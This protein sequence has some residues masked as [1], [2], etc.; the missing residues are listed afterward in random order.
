MHAEVISS[1]VAALRLNQDRRLIRVTTALDP[2]TFIVKRFEGTETVSA[3]HAFAVDLL[4]AQRRLELKQLV[5]QP[6]QLSLGDE[7]DDRV[8]HGYVKEFALI[9]AEG[10]LAAYR[11][12]VAPWFAFLQYTSNCRIFQDLS[13]LEIVEQVFGEYP[14]LA[15]YKYELN[16]GNFPKLSYCVQYNESDFTFVSRLLE[17]A[18]I[19]YTFVHADGAHTMVLAD[20]ST[21]STALGEPAPVAFVS[22]QGVLR[23]PGL[24]SWSARR[25]VGPTAHAVSSFDFKQ[26]RTALSASKARSI[27]IGALPE[28]ERYH[29]DGAARFAD[30]RV[31]DALAAIRSEEAVWP[32]KLFEGAGNSTELQA[33]GCFTLERHPDFIGRSED[34]RQFFVVQLHREGRNNFSSDYSQAEA[35]TYLCSATALRRKIPYRPLRETPQQRM[36]GPQTATVVGPPGEELYADR[37][38]RV[39]VQFHWDR[40]GQFREN[41]SC[42]IRSASPWA[43]A[44]MGGVSPPRVGQEVVVDF[45]D[46]DPD[47]PIITGRVF[48]EDNMPPFGME[49][50]GLKSK[51]VKGGGYNE[52]T[53]HDTAGGELLNMRAQ[54]DMVTTVL[55][56]QNATVKNNK[57]TSVA[58]DH[59]MDVGSNQSISVGA[60]RGITVTGNDMLGVTGTR[61]TSVTGAVTETYQAGETKAIAAAGYSETITG[62]F[63]TT[64]TGNYTSQRTGAWKETVTQTSLRQVIGKVTEQLS[65]GREV[66]ITG[67]DKRSVQGAVEDT[68]VGARTVSVQGDMEQG[69]TGTHTLTANGNMILASGSNLTA[70]VGGAAIEILGEKITISAGGSVIVIDGSGV[71]VNGSEIKLNC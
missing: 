46:G 6:I 25:R 19:Y 47:R 28:L 37:Y 27:P 55:N 45:L 65:A 17:D 51:T 63:V 16:V 40:K 38:G 54:R 58:V 34:D 60:N 4:S 26:P 33:G 2:D 21:A 5:G 18:G 35:P 53:M 52:M 42:W 62:N 29:Y 70:T 43:G 50:S 61:S 1:G 68:N 48:N 39:K 9:G 49:V 13:V 41:S 36:P 67:L 14:Q 71:S 20:D 11:A 64:L 23:T 32:T 31:G 59:R 8:V 3:P 15:D 7:F 30:S 44:D 24:H 10:E 22:D 57:S 12:E 56:D 66:S 69:I